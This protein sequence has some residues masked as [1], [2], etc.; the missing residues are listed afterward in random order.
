MLAEG[1]LL[2]GKYEIRGQLATGGMGE[3]YLAHRRLLGDDVAVKVIRR[4]GPDPSV[5]RERFLRES[6]ACAQLRHPHIVTILDFNIDPQGQPYLVMEYLNGPSLY[7]E[8]KVRDRFDLASVQHLLATVGSA[9]YLAH[10]TG[11]VHRDL[12]PQNIVSHRF[13]GEWFVNKVID[14]GWSR[15]DESKARAHPSTSSARGLFG[16]G[17]VNAGGDG[18]Q[19][20]QYDGSGSTSAGRRPRSREGSWDGGPANPRRDG[21][22]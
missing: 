18:L 2:D 11:I 9:L 3:V 10:S 22:A 12:K 13:E 21:A 8:L 6:R 16:A 14:S 19:A 4:T 1:T 17:A 20:D 15:S 7:E 5:W